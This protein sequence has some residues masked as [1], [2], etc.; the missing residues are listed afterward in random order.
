M[1]PILTVFFLLSFSTFC[2]AQ[3]NNTPSVVGNTKTHSFNKKF[4]TQ[5]IPTKEKETKLQSVTLHGNLTDLKDDR[6]IIAYPRFA[7]FVVDTLEVLHGKFNWSKNLVAPSKA[8][9]FLPGNSFVLYIEPGTITISGSIDSI[10]VA[11][12]KT[13]AKYRE[14]DKSF[15]DLRAQKR[16]LNEKLKEAKGAQEMAIL[17][18]LSQISIK[19]AERENEF[20]KANP[21]NAISTSTALQ[22]ASAGDYDDAIIAYNLLSKKIKTSAVGKEIERSLI[23]TERSRIG[24]KL[25]DFTQNDPDGKPV[26]FS[27][28][29]GKYVFLD[30]WAS[31]CAPC[32]AENSNVLK[33]YNTLKDKNF[34]VIGISVDNDAEQWKKAI[35]DDNMPWTMVSDL[36]GMKNEIAAYF[37]LSGVPFSL[38]IDPQGK[39]IA[40]NLTGV[41]L[42]QKLRQVFGN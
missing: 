9:L 36:K 34:T 22:K 41:R 19:W 31:W 11:G 4:T 2:C 42:H 40:K 16:L 8:M 33:A 20:I 3:T 37:N 32:R 29:K 15:D 27:D 30:F 24:A 14:F 35:K 28:F 38:L 13:D 23:I 6:I 7:T 1:K 26:R 5:S 21:E 10:T 39:V 18:T 25:P 12:S 17:N